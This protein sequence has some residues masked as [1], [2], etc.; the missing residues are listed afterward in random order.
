[1]QIQ[2]LPKTQFGGYFRYEKKV[3]KKNW[4]KIEFGI[5]SKSAEDCYEK[6]KNYAE[7]TIGNDACVAFSFTE[8]EQG[9]CD[10]FKGGKDGPYTYGED[11]PNATCYVMPQGTL[12]DIT[13][14]SR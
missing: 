1:M 10:L 12:V 7:K 3:E 8:N 13:T 5:T 11:N 2:T 4:S 9:N 14:E 6:C